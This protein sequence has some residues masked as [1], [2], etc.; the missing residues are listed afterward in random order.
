VELS[1][2]FSPLNKRNT[3]LARGAC[4]GI[5]G[6]KRQSVRVCVM[7]ITRL[8]EKCALMCGVAGA[9]LM[10]MAGVHAKEIKPLYGF[11]GGHKDGAAPYGGLILDSAGNLY[12][13]T[14]DGG[15]QGCVPAGCGTVFKLAPDGSET[16]LHFFAASNDGE[17]PMAGLIEDGA[18]NLYGTTEYGGASNAGTVFEIAANGTETVLYAFTGTSDGAY[19]F[20]GLIEDSSGNLYGTTEGGGLQDCGAGYCGTV[21]ELAPD[22]TESVLYAFSGSAGDGSHPYGNLI[23]DGAGDFYGTTA[24]GGSANAGTVFELAPDGTETVLYSF[25]GM[26]DGSNPMSG[27]IEDGSGNLYG[28]TFYGGTSKD[29]VVYKLAPD[30]T[31]TVLYAFPGLN[32]GARPYGGVI[33]DSTGNLYG[34]T[35][36]GAW[37]S[38]GLVFKLTPDGTETVHSFCGTRTCSGTPVAGLVADRA[39]NLYGTSLAGGKS[40]YSGTVFKL[41]E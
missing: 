6:S 40:G 23:E 38:Y 1:E 22:G 26:T 34:T 32:D 41:K 29:G 10:P 25:S 28:T 16:I 17:N 30:G 18:G 24:Y 39:G 36:Y 19:P 12:G 33:A 9:L 35:E 20:A 3:S 31:E 7:S 11:R 27:L 5:T 13:T 8:V 4:R 15:I 2:G 21:F 37:N 14:A